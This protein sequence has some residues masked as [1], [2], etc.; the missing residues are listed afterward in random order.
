[1]AH[2]PTY[3]HLSDPGAG[4]DARPW[5]DARAHDAFATSAE[6][7]VAACAAHDVLADSGW[8]SVIDR[9]A[10]LAAEL[11]SELEE[12]GHDVAPRGDTTLVSW[13]SDDP[14]SVVE[15]CAEHRVVVRSFPG[16]PWVRASVGAWNDRSDLDRLLA[17]LGQH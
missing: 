17:V 2:M 14:A 10:G 9:A 5:P 13:R 6:A 1:M 3:T 15:R 16:L 8:E 7:L 12:R 11:A 4:I